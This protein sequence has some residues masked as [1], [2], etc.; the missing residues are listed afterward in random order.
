MRASGA[1]IDSNLLFEGRASELEQSPANSLSSRVKG[2]V[3]SKILRLLTK[4]T[5][6]D[7]K[8]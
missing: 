5:G 7:Y 8:P 6:V 4:S 1:S 2:L 3:D